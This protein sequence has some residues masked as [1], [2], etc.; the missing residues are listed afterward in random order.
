MSCKMPGTQ[1]QVEEVAHTHVVRLSLNMRLMG[2]LSSTSTGH[3]STSISQ[4]EDELLRKLQLSS[5]FRLPV[6]CG[7]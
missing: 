1:A 4:L 2:S 5:A 6:C 7:L 3:G